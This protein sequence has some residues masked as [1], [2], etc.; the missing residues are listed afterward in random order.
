MEDLKTYYPIMS[1]ALHLFLVVDKRMLRTYVPRKRN[2]NPEISSAGDRR[3]D[4]AIAITNGWKTQKCI[5]NLAQIYS[6][7]CIPMERRKSLL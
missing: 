2:S 5:F 1:Y 4:S 6:Y 3:T 7:I